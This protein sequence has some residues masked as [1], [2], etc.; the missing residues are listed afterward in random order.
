MVVSKDESEIRVL[1]ASDRQ[2]RQA[3]KNA[4]ATAGLKVTRIIN[5]PTAAAIAY[6]IDNKRAGWYSKRNVLMF[7]FGGGTLDASLL[8]I[9]CGVFEVKANL[10][11]VGGIVSVNLDLFW[12]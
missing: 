2:P 6:G 1:G 8:S 11:C 7:D 12:D 9:S 4:G 3:T 5:E 10:D